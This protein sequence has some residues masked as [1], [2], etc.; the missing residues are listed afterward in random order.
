MPKTGSLSL[1]AIDEQLLAEIHRR[2]EARSVSMNVLVKD[3]LAEAFGIRAASE[4]PHRS[5]FAAFCGVWTQEEAR[6]FEWRVADLHAVDPK[7]WE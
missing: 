7:D 1:H 4:P 3:T 6:E 5:D 2:A